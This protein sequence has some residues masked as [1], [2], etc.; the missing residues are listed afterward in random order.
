VRLNTFGEANGT[1]KKGPTRSNAFNE[2]I[3][4]AILIM[5]LM[6]YKYLIG[7]A[8]LL[9]I[10]MVRLEDRV[11]IEKTFPNPGEAINFRKKIF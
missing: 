4:Y 9:K 6:D 2:V 10:G 7:V 11:E 3:E 5:R 1:T 8:M